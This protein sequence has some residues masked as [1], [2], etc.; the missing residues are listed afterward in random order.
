MKTMG[1]V[2]IDLFTWNNSFKPEIM[3]QMRVCK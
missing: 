2:N 3:R 1:N